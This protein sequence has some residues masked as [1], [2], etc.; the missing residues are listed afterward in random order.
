M[1]NNIALWNQDDVATAHTYGEAMR[2]P[3]ED[4]AELND[5]EFESREYKKPFPVL[6]THRSQQNGRSSEQQFG[7]SFGEVGNGKPTEPF[8]NNSATTGCERTWIEGAIDINF[9]ISR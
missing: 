1:Q 7:F 5:E 8:A 2:F 6:S 3:S 4:G 9:I